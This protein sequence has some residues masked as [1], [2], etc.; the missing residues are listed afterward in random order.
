M[1]WCL[2]VC[3]GSCWY[4]SASATI[5]DLH[6]RS[7][8]GAWFLNEGKTAMEISGV[9]FV[10]EGDLEAYR[11]FVT[12]HCGSPQDYPVGYIFSQ[13]GKPARNVYY[14]ADGMVKITT[15][16]SAGY[17]R[18]LD[19]HN[20]DTI[21]VLD[22]FRPDVEVVITSEA[23]TPCKAVPISQ[24]QLYQLCAESRNFARDL[25]Y[26]TSDVLRLMCYDAETQSIGDVRTRLADFL[27]LYM[28]S[29]TYQRYGYINMTQDNLASAI[30]SSRVEVARVCAGLKRAG[31]IETG[32]GRLWVRD[33]NAL[34]VIR[35]G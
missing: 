15:T 28:T 20:R 4:L 32:R 31:I 8:R 14:L 30:G 10:L 18:L 1:F 16:N 13:S 25:L 24:G 22:G 5:S 2:S 19:Y 12:A 6:I 34:S 7:S 21:F 26:Y 9:N 33:A 29:K 35:R 27:L 17:V 11:G 3:I 23:M